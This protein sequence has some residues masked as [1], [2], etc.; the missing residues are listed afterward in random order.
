MTNADR[1]QRLD[2][3]QCPPINPISMAQLSEACKLKATNNIEGT[4]KIS[5]EKVRIDQPDKFHLQTPTKTQKVEKLFQK[6]DENVSH[7]PP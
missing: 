1:I 4:Q 6:N 3:T 5:G 7:H 2:S